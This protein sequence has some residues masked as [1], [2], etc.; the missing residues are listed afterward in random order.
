[1]EVHAPLRR[2]VDMVEGKIHQHGL[3]APHTAPEVDAV[4]AGRSLPQKATEQSSAV[5]RF[6]LLSEPV[7]CDDTAL[8][9]LVGLQLTGF[10]ELGV[11]PPD[12]TAHA[13]AF[14]SRTRFSVPVKL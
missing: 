1:M 13:G 3:P 11:C 2:D 9:R 5:R 10:D 4:A 14:G 6:K 8:L 7:E 12:S